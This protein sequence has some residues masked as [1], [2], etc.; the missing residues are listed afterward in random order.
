MT[1]NVSLALGYIPTIVGILALVFTIYYIIRQVREVR[2]Y[3]GISLRYVWIGLVLSLS[4]ISIIL[5]NTLHVPRF[6]LQHPVFM[7]FIAYSI[8][9]TGAILRYRLLLL[10]GIGFAACA[11]IS[12]YLSLEY[13]VLVEAVAW[14]LAFIIPGHFMYIKRKNAK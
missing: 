10:G 14:L 13:Q 9:I 2:T 5:M 1:Y 11:L 12:S 8:V 3:I 7:V 4:L 6:E